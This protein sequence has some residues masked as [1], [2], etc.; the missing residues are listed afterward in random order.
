M[1]NAKDSLLKRCAAVSKLV[2]VYQDVVDKCAFENVDYS[3]EELVH[4]QCTY[5]MSEKYQ[6]HLSVLQYK[7]LV[8]VFDTWEFSSA[9]WRDI[10]NDSKNIL[11]N[12]SDSKLQEMIL[13]YKEN[14]PKIDV[15]ITRII[16][17]YIYA[18]F[19]GSTYDEYY[20]GMMNL[21][22]AS[23][24][25]IHFLAVVNQDKDIE[26]L[27]IAYLY[28]RELEHSTENVIATEK[29]FDEN[30]IRFD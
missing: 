5:S 10:V 2:Q 21:A 6:E 11:S 18:F 17:Y 16:C 14:N 20:S 3:V 9:R 12:M 7:N 8:N 25:L 1:G 13:Q 24:L 26:L 4:N 22:L 27:Q 30:P 19:C 15:Y 29:Y 23:G 28:A